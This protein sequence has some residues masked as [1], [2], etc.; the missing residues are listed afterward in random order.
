[1]LELPRDGVPGWVVVD[2][3]LVPPPPP[4]PEPSPGDTIEGRIELD[5]APPPGPPQACP[6]V[7]AYFSMS[8]STSLVK[9]PH[10][11]YPSTCIFHDAATHASCWS[12]GLLRASFPIWSPILSRNGVK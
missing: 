12:S 9:E 5:A 7:L 8:L 4:P 3:T 11:A 2:R 6:N 10:A 1:M